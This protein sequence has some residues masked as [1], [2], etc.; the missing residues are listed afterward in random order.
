MAKIRRR[1]YQSKSKQIRKAMDRMY[2]LIGWI[3][4]AYHLSDDDSGYYQ[5]KHD[6]V[7]I[8]EEATDI[9]EKAEGFLKATPLKHY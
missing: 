6:L 9:A 4:H 5:M 2:S 3:K 8:A 1:R 7:K